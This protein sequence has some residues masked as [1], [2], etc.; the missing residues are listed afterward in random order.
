MGARNPTVTMVAAIASVLETSIVE[1][2][3]PPMN[4]RKETT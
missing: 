2:L 4:T 1:L 3:K